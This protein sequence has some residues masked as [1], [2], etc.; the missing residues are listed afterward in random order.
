LTADV[1]VAGDVI[2]N[3]TGTGL[4]TGG[5]AE[6]E[7]TDPV[8]ALQGSTTADAP[9][10]TFFLN[11]LGVEDV[12][13]SYNVR[14]IDGTSDDTN[15]QVALQ[16]RVGSSGSWSNVTTGTNTYIAD[17]TTGPGLSDLV[18]AVSG[19]LPADADNRAEV[20][21]RVLTTNAPS[22]DEWV[23]IDDIVITAT[24]AATFVVAPANMHGWV[25]DVDATGGDG[26]MVAG[27]STPPLG[28]GSARLFTGTEG[29]DSTE[30]RTANFTGD[31]LA[32]IVSLSYSTYP[33]QWNVPGTTG[34]Q[35]PYIIL[36]VD[37]DGNLG[38]PGDTDL[39][40]FE[41]AY[42][43]ADAYG[44]SLPD[45]GTVT[46]NTW[47]TWDATTGGWWS[48]AGT[49]GASP[50][51]GVKSLATIVAAHPNA[52]VRDSGTGGLRLLQG[53]ASPSD[54]FEGYVDNVLIQV[55][56]PSGSGVLTA[57][58]FEPPA[59]ESWGDNDW[60]IA[61][62]TDFSGT[63]TAGDVVE[64]DA[65]DGDDA[66][67]DLIFGYNAFDTVAT[68]L[69]AAVDFGTIHV[70]AG[71][72]VESLAIAQN[73]II[74]GQSD[75]QS[76]VDADGASTGIEIDGIATV[77]ISGI[78]LFN[79]SSTGIHVQ[80]ELTLAESSISDGLMG[81]WVDGGTLA[82]ETTLVTGASIFGVQVSDSG[83]ATIDNSEITGTGSTAA[84]VIV[85]SG[86]A[87]ITGSKL[88]SNNRG[89]LVNAA[90]TASVTGSD[91]SGN[92]VAGVANATATAVDASGNWWGTNSEAGVDTAA[93]GLVD[94]TPYLNSGADGDVARGFTGDYSHLHVTALGEQTSGDRIQ[95][96]IDLVDSLGTVTVHDGTYDETVLV[97]KSI[98]LESANEH[99]AFIAPTS[100]AQQTVVT[101]DAEDV[102]VDGFAIQVN[103]ND[104]ALL[105]GTAPIAP[106]GI[107]A[108]GTLMDG[109]TISNNLITSIGSNASVNWTGSPSLTV[110]AAGI[111]LN[112]AP[113]GNIP[114]VTLTGNNVSIGSGSSFFQRG[115][116]LS[117]LNAQITGNVLAGVAN[118][119]I[120]QF[121]SGGPS[122]I[123]GNDFVGAHL[124][125]GAGLV[126][127]DPNA[128][129]DITIT[130]NDFTT[131]PTAFP[132][133][134][135]QVNR[136]AS[137]STILI[138][139]NRFDGHTVGVD[140]GGAS[141]VTVSN[142]QFT[143]EAGI[144]G[145]VHV[146]VD[147]QNASNNASTATVNDTK[148]FGNTFNV[149]SGATGTAVVV[150]DNLP[151]STYSLTGVEIGLGGANIYGSGLTAGI[152]VLGGVVSID[153]S[154]ADADAGLI[155]AGGSAT[156]ADSS[157]TDNDTGIAVS[158]TGQLTIGENNTISG[159]T[160]GLVF[161]G[162]NVGLTGLDLNNLSIDNVSGDYIT[163]ANFAFDDLDLI[164]TDL[165]LGGTHVGSM[166]P[167][168]LFAASDKITDEI[169]NNTLGLVLLVA[170][171]IFVTP[172]EVATDIDNDYTRIVNALEAAADGY[173]IL[174]GPNSLADA[175]FNWN[176][177]F[178]LADWELGNDGIGG[179][180][181]DWGANLPAGLSDITITADE[182]DAVTILGPGDLASTS[183]ETGLLAY[184]TGDHENV[185]ISNFTI[186]GI[187]N[188][189]GFFYGSGADFSGL[190]IE[191][192]HII[193]PEDDP[194]DDFHNIGIHY[195]FGQDITIQGNDI[196]LVDG[197]TDS[198]SIGI[199]SNTHATDAYDGLEITDNMITVTGDGDGGVIGVWENGH[200]HGSDILVAGNTFQGAGDPT[201]NDQ[202]AFL[203]TSHSGASSL[204][205]Y[206]VNIIDNAQVG[207]EWLDEFD[208][209]PIDY[210]GTQAVRLNGNTLT[211]VDTGVMVGG[212]NASALLSNNS[213][214][215][216]GAMENVGIGV[217]VAAGSTVTLDGSPSENS[218][219]G[220][221]FGIRSAGTLFVED[222][223][224]SIHGNVTGIAVTGGTATITNNHIY[225]NTTGIDV[226]GGT[227]TISGNN[228]HLNATGV[229]FATT[230]AG[231]LD[232]NSFD[233]GLD[234]N[235]TDLLI[236]S[237]AGTITIDSG[238]LFAGDDYFINNQSTQSFDLTGGTQ[239]FQGDSGVLN[240]GTLAGSF[241][242]EDRMFHGPDNGTSGVI[243]WNAD[244]MY[245]TT[246]GTGDNDETI[247]NAVDTAT[248]GDTINVEAGEFDEQVVINKSL[249]LQGAGNS[250]VIKPSSAAV[251]TTVYNTGVQVGANFNNINLGGVV[252]VSGVGTAGV[253]IRNLKIDAE[254][255]T[256]LPGGAAQGVGLIFGETAGLIQ[257]VTV[258][259]IDSIPLATRSHGM[260]I[261]A[262]GGPAVNVE[263]DNA[264]VNGY[265]R[266]G[267]L[268]RGNEL[269][270]D[271]HDSDITGPG[272]IG[273]DN[274]PNGIT[275][276]DTA[277]GSIHDNTISA[278][279]FTGL[280]FL[281][282]GILLFDAADGVTIEDNEVFDYDDGI[283]IN[284]SDLAIVQ[285]NNLHD[286]VKGIRIETGANNNIIT[287]NT[288]TNNSQFGIDVGASA[289]A[290]NA[291]SANT[292][293]A[294]SGIGIN[295][296]G[297][298]V[299]FGAGN[300]VTGGDTGL[301]V[302]G[303]ATAIVGNTL[304]DIAFTGQ[305]G[306]YIELTGGA[307]DGVEI[308]GTLATFGGSTADNIGVAANYAL[309]DRIVHAIDNGAVGF[310]R[311]DAGHVYVTPNSF[312]SPATDADIQRAVDAAINGDV[313]HVQGGAYVG[314]VNTAGK[315]ITLD[316][317]A[318]PAQVTINGDLTLD[319]DD[320]LVL[321]IDGLTPGA[322]HDQLVVN[323]V[324]T[325]GGAA[326]DADG[327]IVATNGQSVRII[328]N[329]DS[330]PV[331][332]IFAGLDNGDTV[333]INS[334]LF[335]IFYDGGD[336]ND[337][338]LV[339]IPTAPPP[340]VV[341]V[342]DSWAGLSNGT[343]A[344][345]A[346]NNVPGWNPPLSGGP[347][348]ANGSAIGYDQFDTIEEGLAAVAAGG[349]VF[350]Y[351]GTYYT[352]GY[353]VDKSV[354]IEGESRSGVVI[355]PSV[356]DSN[357]SGLFDGTAVHGFLVRADDVTITT[358]TIDGEANALLTPGRN[359][360]RTAVLVNTPIGTFDN[361]TVDSIDVLNIYR[362]GIQIS[363]IGAHSA[364]HQIT[365]NLID[366][367][368]LAGGGYGIA[369]FEADA[370]ISGN[371][372]RNAALGIAT[373][374]IFSAANAGVA[375]I[376]GNTIDNVGI[377]IYASGLAGGSLVGGPTLADR[378]E[379]DLTQA[380]GTAFDLGIIVDYVLGTVT[381]QNNEVLASQGDS[382]I[383]LYHNE[384]AGNP[385]E[386]LDNVLTATGSTRNA[387]G[388]G[389]GIFSTD[390]GVFNGD[391]DGDSYA[392]IRGNTITDF[393]GGIELDRSGVSP[394]GGRNVVTTI[395]GPNAAD[396][397]QIS[398]TGAAGSFGI[399]VFEIDGPD[400]GGYK[401]VATIE[402]NDSS[403]HGFAVGIDVDGGSAAISGNHIYDNGAG[404]RF[405][406]SGAGSVDNND[407]DGGA[408]DDNG[409]DLLLT[410]TAGL[411][412]SLAGN[413]FAGDTFFIDNQTTQDFDL[414]AN[415]TTFDEANNF[416]IEDKMH[417]EMDTDLSLGN[418]RI[419]WVAGNR[420]VTTPGGGSTDSGI[421]RGI[422]TADAGD[423][424]NV[425]AGNY[426]ENVSIT[427][428]IDVL[429]D[430]S[431]GT[432][433]TAASG[434]VFTLSG[435][436]FGTAD[437]EVTIRYMNLDGNAGAAN[438]G[439]FIQGTTVL[440]SFEL[441]DADVTGFRL[442]GFYVDA[443]AY[444]GSD[445]TTTSQVQ[446]VTLE[447]LEFT[448]NGIGGG[449]GTADIQFFGFN[450]NATLT[451]ITAV[452][453]RVQ[454]VVDSLSTG[455][456]GSI[457]FRGV[458]LGNGTGVA[459]MGTVTLDN[460]DVSGKYRNQ[461]IGIQR[462]SDVDNLSFTDVALGGVG[463]EIT[464]GFGASL[465]FDAAGFGSLGTPETVDLGNT[466]FR[467]LD[468]LS[469]Q[470]HEIEFA[471]DNLYTF[472]RADAT[473]TTWTIGGSD[474]AAGSLTVAEAYVVEDRILHYVD[475]LN[476]THALAFGPYK[477]FVDIQA[478]KAFITDSPESGL[479]GE[480][481]INR[482]V[483]VVASG[484]TVHVAN[485]TYTQDVD[486]SA[487]DVTLSFGSSAGQVTING[488]V[489]FDGNDTLHM[490]INGLTPGTQHDQLVVNGIVTLGDATLSTAGST[491]TATQGDTLTLIAN[492]MAD[493]VSGTFAGIPDGN[494]ILVNGEPF[495][496]NYDGDTGN[497][498][499]LTRAPDGTDPGP[500]PAPNVVFVHDDWS[501]YS[502]GVD[503]DGLAG[504]SMGNGTAIGYDQFDTIS[505][506]IQAV[507]MGGTIYV[508]AGAYVE[509][510]NIDKA[511][512]LISEDAFFATT[513]GDGF[514]DSI[515]N[516]SGVTSVVVTI[517]ASNVEMAGFTVEGDG[518][519][520][521]GIL[522]TT[523]FPYPT[524]TGLEIRHNAVRNFLRRG[525]QSDTYLAEFD[526][527][528]NQVSNITG[529]AAAIAIF[530]Y[531]G[532]GV[533]GTA[534]IHHNTITGSTVGIGGQQSAGMQVHDNTIAMVAG[535]I[536]IQDS[537][538]GTGA[539]PPIGATE[540]FEDNIIS[541]GDAD[542]AGLVVIN[543]AMDVLVAGNTVTTPGTGLGAFG[544][545]SPSTITFDN[546]TVMADD[547]G[548]HITTDTLGL[549]GF[550][551]VTAIIQNDNDI[552]GAT[553][554][555]LVEELGGADADVTITGND[556]SIHGNDVGIDVVG[557][558]VTVS[559][560]DIYDN[561]IA[562]LRLTNATGD[563]T[564][565]D[566]HNNYVGI[567]VNGASTLTL[568][569]GTVND[570][571]S[572][573]LIVVGDGSVQSISVD[574]TS[575]SSNST[576]Q[577]VSAGH[578]D[579]TLFDFGG[580]AGMPGS[581]STASFENVTI[582]SDMPDYAIQVRGR[583]GTIAGGFSSNVG[584]TAEVSFDN[585]DIL[586]TQ[587]R[588]GMLIQQYASLSGFSFNDVT[589]DSVAVGGLVIFDAA[590]TLDLGNTTFHDS[591]TGGNGTGNGTGFDI[592]TSINNV[593]AT[594]VTF[595]D[596]S[597]VAL[598]KTDLQDNFAIED[599]VGHSVDAPTPIPGTAFVDWIATGNPFDDAVFLTT[600]S[601]APGPPV[602][603]TAASVQ[604]AIDVTDA[605]AT[606]DTLYIQ[607]GT[608]TDTAQI[609]IDTEITVIGEGKTTTI[610]T[611]NFNTA[612]SGDGRGWWLVNPG[613]TLA[614][615]HVGFDGTGFLTYQ[616]IRHKGDGTIDNVAFDEIKYQESGP[617]YSGV[618]VAF[619]PAGGGNLDVT[620]STFSEIG[621][622]G[623][624]Y[625]GNGTG[626]PAVTGTF[627]GNTYTGKGAGD[628]LDYAV[629]VGAGAVVD[630]IGNDISGNL[631]V[632]GDGS[633]SA[634]VLV[635]TFFADGS[636][637][638][639]SGNTIDGNTTGVYVGFDSADT[640]AVTID[641]DTITNS[642]GSGVFVIGGS[643]TVENDT[644]LTG[645]GTGITVSTGGEA[646]IIDNDD[647][648][649]GN[650]IGIDVDGGTALVQNNDLNGNTIGVR[651]QNGGIADLGQFGAGTNFTGLG[652]S[653]GGN[654]FSLY[655]AAATA[656][657]GAIVNL[658]TGGAYSAAGPQGLPL[659]VPAFNN[660]WDDS[661]PTGIE[662]VIW[663]DADNS[664][665]GFVDY[666][667]LANL[668]VSLDP[669]PT[670]TT[671]EDVNEGSAATVYGEFTN[672]AQSHRVTVVWGDGSPNS[673]QILGPGVFTF[674]ITS[675][676][677][678]TYTDDPNGPT[679]T[680]NRPIAVTVEEVVTPTNFITD[681]SLSV[682]VNNVAPVI[683]L[684]DQDGDN[685][686]NEGQT[687]N[688]LVGPKVDPGTDTIVA[689]T[690]FWGDS[691]STFVAGNPLTAQQLH[692][693][694]YA[695]GLANPDRTITIDVQDEDGTW[696]PAGSLTI[697]VHNVPPTAG[698]FLAFNSNVNEGGTTTVFFTGPESDPGSPDGPFHYAFDFD[699]DD[700]Y[701][702]A[703]EAGDGTYSGSGTSSFA[704][705]PSSFLADDDDSPRTINARVID[706][707]G[708]YTDYSLQITIENVDPVVDA[709][710]DTTVV[711]N[712]VLS[713]TVTFTDPGADSPWVV[714]IDWDEDAIYD[715]SFF[716]PGHSFDIAD[717]STWT[718]G[719]GDVGQ[720]FTVVVQVDDQDGGVD[721]DTFDVTVV[722]D[723]L[724]VI[725]FEFNASG[726]DV[727]F[728]RAPNLGDLNLYDS[729]LDGSPS[730]LEA[731]DVTLVRNGSEQILGS[732]VWAADTN[733]L[734]FVKTGGVL[735]SG[736]YDV[737]LVSS[738]IG[739]HDGGNLLDGDGDFDDNEVGDDYENS[740]TI[741][742]PPINYRVVSVGDF[743][744]GTGQ[745]VNVPTVEMGGAHLP[746]L[747]S[748][749]SGV[750]S[751][752]VDILYDPTL[753]NIS[754]AY[755][756]AAPTSAGGWS[757]T[758]N[759]ISIDANHTLLKLT[760]S[761]VN[762][763]SGSDV[764]IIKLDA[765]VPTDAL[766]GASQVIRL[767][768]LRVNEDLLPS[769]ADYAIHKAVYVGDADG[770]GL[771]GGGDSTLISRVVVALDSGFDAHDWTDP[772]IVGDAS[773]DGTLSGLD[774]SYVAQEAVDIDR[775]EVPPIPMVSLM[776]V[777]GGI[778]PEYSVDDSIPAQLGESVTVP[779]KLEVMPGET[780][781]VGGTFVLNYDEDLLTYQDPP[782]DGPG[783]TVLVVN[784][785]VPGV[786]RVSYQRT[787][788]NP[789]AVGESVIADLEFSVG[790]S[791]TIGQVSP[792][793][794]AARDPNELGLTWTNENGSAIITGL[795]GDYNNDEIVDVA[796]FVAWMKLFGNSVSSYTL[797]DGDGDTDVDGN[798]YNTFAE[799]FG[800]SV[801]GGGG[802]GTATQTSA[803]ESTNSSSF[804]DDF[805]TPVAISASSANESVAALNYVAVAA[806]EPPAV[807]SSE[808]AAPQ[809][810]AR[811]SA[812]DS[813]LA[814]FATSR[815]EGRASH[816]RASSVRSRHI[817]AANQDDS[818]L[819]NLA[820]AARRERDDDCDPAIAEN[821]HRDS[822]EA[823][824]ELFAEFDEDKALLAI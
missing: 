96:G 259:D 773:G 59:E 8:V 270:I 98:L 748:N 138:D 271:I 545:F 368:E 211:D 418:G 561:T 457:Q 290:G 816:A 286:N 708:G 199:Q 587:Q 113:S 323:G 723:T 558:S 414:S 201:S 814:D 194:A 29:D 546:N 521:Y 158:G 376:Q 557:G 425:E 203:I 247:Q 449:G 588:F 34:G 97:D 711:A 467:G 133:T 463:S 111:V 301:V 682:D 578:G 471:P 298:S 474:I 390:N 483:A 654:D 392:V 559:D 283:I 824:D 214:T 236:E 297:G 400:N 23:G 822:F 605:M 159:G 451:N 725:D 122:L 700:I 592:A 769:T 275:V 264:T 344:D 673:V 612:G 543:S 179:T 709:G 817:A 635:T 254:N 762:A 595:L 155:V 712:S 268:N 639:L 643:V 389:V 536:G 720:T 229:R 331:N 791:G 292:I 774:A 583:N 86:N 788:L 39:L 794:I 372:I 621:R 702:E 731:P 14:D 529:D 641:G 410:S 204:V 771:Y 569:G 550:Q 168:Q 484:G 746:V 291:L 819:L 208:S 581:P 526:I 51:A 430:S 572:N 534:E 187:A 320:T 523:P 533:P 140:V 775:P 649:T 388:E 600:E 311:V 353:I 146:L 262:V 741:D 668:V 623:V 252:Q 676:T 821:E 106:V 688:L 69:A 223:D 506:A 801:G 706:N 553:T 579:I 647:S 70:L 638:Q 695:D 182:D 499:V 165:T 373:N 57:Y 332:G 566:I 680:I 519:D 212:I 796:D 310:V 299:S 66:I 818:L 753:L 337:V 461:M 721:T 510:I 666:A 456:R 798:D 196:D 405:T 800:E 304:N 322:E 393:V 444:T 396:K 413:D 32:D 104:D 334:Q 6:F 422:D 495:F 63:L 624:L 488:N 520:S 687:F 249:T 370:L 694:L 195:A 717:Y 215:N 62:D 761:G 651:I 515:I 169:D 127:A 576:G 126:I 402:D 473:L 640:S 13:V 330:D 246:P 185:T 813:V 241:R 554:G 173:T 500:Q 354:A 584:S 750:Q 192:M 257:N 599:R 792:I 15:Q 56:A 145:F 663:H 385:V 542:S 730:I 256:A 184:N 785:T 531:G 770:S 166:T 88:N 674:T 678:T 2:A 36:H 406:N 440:D 296:L 505:E 379:I 642:T 782:A 364:G 134:A 729:L 811:H 380:G 319:G 91:L 112:D 532:G 434:N 193:V 71:T 123:D 432:T 282:G 768:G 745:D 653:T 3:Q 749:A 338:V 61:T 219:V 691:Q 450:N 805:V 797:A 269:T 315:S 652:V 375:T 366:D 525:I 498:V 52:I 608:Y 633:T 170:N 527:H 343:D 458:G 84:G 591:Y 365:N 607:N 616:A 152:H 136:N 412:S 90:G 582:N 198:F 125:G 77:Q 350:V 251:L 235:L 441:S 540:T 747:I 139:D 118:D 428:D 726:F 445:P 455:A 593:D 68:A 213:L 573:G 776:H 303:A 619:F 72:F 11:T 60:V 697:Q 541:G 265:A 783:W 83:V 815:S 263:V 690:I 9:Y 734:S 221:N 280:S 336:G 793:T 424:V 784:A 481:S 399:L 552:S 524:L 718:Y 287:G 351:D 190:T 360:F 567:S 597:D 518:S 615:S 239:T 764:E 468:P 314:S 758:K 289:G 435:A 564:N 20:Q 186:D 35:A 479:V 300:T 53:F 161:D 119:L 27:P 812:R 49:A 684:A 171:T 253:T 7:I 124:T 216:S 276:I 632:A 603:S 227:A 421:Q 16:Y 493:A 149:A 45:Q 28:Q 574:G 258:E 64:S 148:I 646:T 549:N 274:V 560:N 496:V 238:N 427:K 266:T 153:E 820:V 503:A 795:P 295:L 40:F 346:G 22:S 683:P 743:S 497:D 120:F 41:P 470:R 577:P 548:I 659:D 156:V 151:G 464:G 476:P 349:Y 419:T 4:T 281:A 176:E 626:G 738:S 340:N 744:R 740:F 677:A 625:F 634:G 359:N 601:Y 220:F 703:G 704:A 164:G 618:G 611:K 352:S 802:G 475:K 147:S 141:G 82:M 244:T 341:F 167:A 609:L 395:G 547:V 339:C 103:Q 617:A 719:N 562:G 250:T 508:Y 442:Y 326:L 724:R 671:N 100:G 589:F 538:P 378:N 686:I 544:S 206:N 658:N 137:N 131:A 575:F 260:W 631:G 452:G 38:T 19:V 172:V 226:S 752:D 660:L 537:N 409:T 363:T 312:V 551:D 33:V 407:F 501:I 302:D 662:N 698:S 54:V 132:S 737:T 431:S 568:T 231:S 760:I 210:T 308:D 382:A 448:N 383:W 664:A 65:D 799:H 232:N 490:E 93:V 580:P 705:V 386:I 142:N 10:L 563:L 689:Y 183:L 242:I 358:L 486:T 670:V 763:L 224:T 313:V 789:A 374:Y 144:A 535:G 279:H 598:D 394:V 200:T 24:P 356:E 110:R 101:V 44:T 306:N 245:V 512:D 462:Y 255:V 316:L 18:T 294:T 650:D 732:I 728:N 772:R 454:N 710:P 472:L 25:F 417:H 661:S 157:F 614:L 175:T 466:L 207:F 665:L 722:E 324:V 381:V 284:D 777:G 460:V 107:A 377:G 116:W 477:G 31:R 604:R 779:V 197:G 222:N 606:K 736:S 778:D 115:V 780:N 121:A 135:L 361:L 188:A 438:A 751:V 109:L 243:Y 398:G 539:P 637:A 426:T 522:A 355:A 713:H 73:V 489:T 804:S 507:A 225:D 285:G 160:T 739:F 130:D 594:E 433:L 620:N 790:N 439:V 293:S 317:G 685:S 87:D 630:I 465:R 681:N 485:G 305:S 727:T 767:L 81:I 78:G 114:S 781:M 209:I 415:G 342:D 478:G 288:I 99:G 76:L 401:N 75:A 511:L 453:N 333:L 513:A 228:I 181:D 43:D 272:A 707:D 89:L 610:L 756:G 759:F 655:T 803:T 362:R 555:I 596:S 514:A 613:I 644:T 108:V 715:E 602:L 667:T 345:G 482:G 656:T 150:E 766:Y 248:A 487:N 714:S 627:Q 237:S 154:I 369:V 504:D 416:R 679:Q 733:M 85:S 218:I 178:A 26:S 408:S 278:G 699:G 189:I 105:G 47:Q 230:G 675:N 403:I 765:D 429:G 404:I 55:A 327:A 347:P 757:I 528:H 480:G 672:D 469:A 446:N 261:N 267:I 628:W 67:S 94:F 180:D 447:D 648:I 163:L 807:T 436:G 162:P 437:D 273:P 622:I 95:E 387:S 516:P 48:L 645:N 371:T 318:S 74:E 367:I 391:E 517:S 217:D 565:N 328:D 129:S 102:T 277:H 657:S 205:R 79:F 397:N 384:L 693:H 329:D 357:N 585:V 50:G 17:A 177:A 174:L 586:G 669:L 755:L 492:D 37:L 202:T 321:E 701:G 191:N 494:V 787:D 810:V 12:T 92:S 809:T 556:D 806:P 46:L 1:A 502:D 696:S 735:A 571:T 459:P 491:I 716:V 636:A 234:D 80:G 307:L 58:D 5:V 30:L 335:Q 420:Y 128:D 443:S 42:Q 240:Q 309:E 530:N 348:N 590:G 742:P 823:I 21:V 143:S 570:N 509:A 423:T 411:I 808:P 117:Q 233:N 692:S 754:D 325:L 629:E 786:L